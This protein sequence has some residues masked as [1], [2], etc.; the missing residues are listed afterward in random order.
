MARRWRFEREASAVAA[1]SHLNILA[2]MT[3]AVA[4][5]RAVMELFE[6]MMLRDWLTRGDGSAS[7]RLRA[8]FAGLAAR[9]TGARPPGPEAPE[10]LR[11]M[12]GLSDLRLVWLCALADAPKVSKRRFTIPWWKKIFG[13][14][15]ED[16]I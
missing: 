1:L 14:W 15:G 8:R 13:P 7:S 2:I 6:G 16:V 5:S 9:T 12:D 3:S 11:D 4:G 10:R